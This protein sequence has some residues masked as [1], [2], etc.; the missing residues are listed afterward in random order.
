MNP[1]LFFVLASSVS[2]T[3]CRHVA[4]E[5]AV[6]APRRDGPALSFN[7]GTTLGGELSSAQ[8]YGRA[9]VILFVTTFDLGSQVE[10]ARLNE[11]VRYHRPR[12]NAAAIVLEAPKYALLAEA[13]RTSLRLS[14]PVAIA[15]DDTR[16]GSG[17]FGRIARVPTLVVLDARGRETWRKSGIVPLR[18]LESVLTRAQAWAGAR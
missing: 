15:D 7:Y 11:F 5:D 10:A 1:V 18:E 12:I 6:R 17:P 8:M 9:S 16:T 13:F 14:Y 2:F 4:D 3:A